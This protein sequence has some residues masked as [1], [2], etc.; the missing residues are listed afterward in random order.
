MRSPVCT[1]TAAYAVAALTAAQLVACTSSTGAHQSSPAATRTVIGT[2]T[3]T[4]SVGPT[5][6]VST[7]P[8]T[9][10][11]AAACPLLPEQQ[12]AQ[13]VGMR[14]ARITVLHSGGKVVGCRFY[15]VQNSPYHYS[16]HL[17]GPN[18]PAIE[19]ETVRYAS[20]IAAH[21]AFV[22]EAERGANPQQEQIGNTTGV[23][24]QIHF[25]APDHG[26]DWA[27]AFNIGSTKV[28]VRTVVAK[29]ALNV[30]QVA[31]VIARRL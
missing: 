9:V 27:C 6:P 11:R 24:F 23:C 10:A 4:P 31:R 21:N 20:M 28:S 29:P 12:A 22:I 18:Q 1:R 3:S 25:Y 19:I 8:T 26:Q 30:A 16:E 13:R 2:T 17:P 14:L 15:A 7:G 5:T